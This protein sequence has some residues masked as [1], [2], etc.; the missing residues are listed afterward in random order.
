MKLVARLNVINVSAGIPEALHA[1]DQRIASKTVDVNSARQNK[2]S[3][4]AR[5]RISM[6]LSG[7]LETNIG[8]YGC[9]TEL[10]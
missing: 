1:S 9:S 5:L 7:L 6:L 4:E 10:L 3:C 2:V 8:R